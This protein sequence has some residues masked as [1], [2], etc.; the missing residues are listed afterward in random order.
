MSCAAM[1]KHDK[2]EIPASGVPEIGHRVTRKDSDESGTV[3]DA[4]GQIKMKLDGGGTSY[5]RRGEPG[6]VRRSADLP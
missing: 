5:F 4:N 6:N 3:V 2:I 1:S